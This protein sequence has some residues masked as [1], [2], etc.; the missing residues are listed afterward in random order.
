MDFKNL[1]INILAKAKNGIIILSSR[2]GLG[3][4]VIYNYSKY[5]PRETLNSSILG[6]YGIFFY[7]WLQS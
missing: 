5:V 1:R 4:N 3:Q 2:S 7:L 6:I